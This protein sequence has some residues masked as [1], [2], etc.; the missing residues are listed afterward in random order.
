MKSLRTL[1]SI[2]DNAALGSGTTILSIVDFGAKANSDADVSALEAEIDEIVYSLYGLANEIV[3][4]V[5]D[6]AQDSNGET[7]SENASREEHALEE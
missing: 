3:A 7:P 6:V 2:L 5:K 4:S 1:F